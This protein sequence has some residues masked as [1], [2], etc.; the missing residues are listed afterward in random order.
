MYSTSTSACEE[1]LQTRIGFQE[2]PLVLSLQMPGV[3]PILLPCAGR[4]EGSISIHSDVGSGNRRLVYGS[5]LH[6]LREVPVHQLQLV[7]RSENITLAFPRRPMKRRSAIRK[8]SVSREHASSMC[9]ARVERQV[10]S[11]TNRFSVLRNLRT[12]SGPK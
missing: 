6:F 12:C 4:R 8:A 3:V 2:S 9:I 1:H 11:R 5:R 7:P 10:A